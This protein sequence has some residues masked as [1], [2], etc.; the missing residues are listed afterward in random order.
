MNTPN[1]PSIVGSENR[2]G[3][4]LYKKE[5]LCSAIAISQLFGRERPK[6]PATNNGDTHSALAYPLRC[7]WR[8]NPRRSSDAPIQFL[9]S[10]PKKRLRHAVD[11]VLMR[12]RVREAFRLNHLQYPLPQGC[13]FDVAFIYVGNGLEQ[14]EFVERAI[15]RLLKKIQKSA[16]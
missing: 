10:I 4:R 12:R 13:R 9:I 1:T 11:R 2:K 8:N 5:K 14:Y 6:G 7:V 15:H 3:F 16:Q